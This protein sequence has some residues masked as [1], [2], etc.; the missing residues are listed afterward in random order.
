MI[1]TWRNGAQANVV[2]SVIDENFN[3]LAKDIAKNIR[4]YTSSEIESM[5]DKTEGLI[6]YNTTTGKW[7]KNNQG[8]WEDYF[9]PM[10]SSDYAHSFNIG[11]ASW[12]NGQ[13]S[14]SFDTH[15]IPNPCVKLYISYGGVYTEVL[16]GVSID[17][18]GNITL[19]TDIPF[20]GRVVIK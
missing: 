7:L 14:I 12:E 15:K 1:S 6:V 5:T 19:S 4:A 2:K 8:N 3:Y 16:G 13:I 17:N 18:T 9:F 20:A 10:E 11:I